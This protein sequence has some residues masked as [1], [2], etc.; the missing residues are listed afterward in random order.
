ME[1][2]QHCARHLGASDPGQGLIKVRVCRVP[3][4]PER[5][6]DPE[7][8]PLKSLEGPV[9]QSGHVARVSEVADAIADRADRSVGLRKGFDLDG[10]AGAGDLDC[11]ALSAQETRIADRRVSVQASE[12]LAKSR[13]Q[14]L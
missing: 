7:L 5:I 14:R 13:F 6:D 12:N 3:G 1:I 9:V 2:G 8:D 10:P 11:L 4:P